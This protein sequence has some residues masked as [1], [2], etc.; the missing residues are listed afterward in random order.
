MSPASSGRWARL[1]TESRN[2]RSRRLDTMP[3]ERVVALLLDEDRRAILAAARERRSIARAARLIDLTPGPHG[4]ELLEGE[5][6][7]IHERMAA[8]TQR[9]FPVLLQ[10]LADTERLR[11]ATLIQAGIHVGRRRGRIRAQ[12]IVQEPFAP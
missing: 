9:I 5:P 1:L 8:G 4:V 10:A 7:R 2:A 3:T 11:L 6:E 12:D